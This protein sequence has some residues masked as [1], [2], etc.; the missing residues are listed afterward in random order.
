MGV[1]PGE[2]VRQCLPGEIRKELDIHPY[3]LDAQDENGMTALHHAAYLG[4]L[5]VCRML[6]ERGA[7]EKGNIP[8]AALLIGNGADINAEANQGL[9]P[10]HMAAVMG[11]PGMVNLLLSKG[12]DAS[13][14]DDK[15]N[16]AID[17]AKAML[18]DAVVPLMPEGSGKDSGSSGRE[19]R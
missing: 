17:F 9:T 5:D 2:R 4:N 16:K 7:V 10:L 19:N 6:V 3:L 11:N 12:A 14:P 1:P 15:G 8:V 13:I 18:R